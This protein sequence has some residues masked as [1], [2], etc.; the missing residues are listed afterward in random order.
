MTKSANKIISI[1]IKD[2]KHIQNVLNRLQISAK[3]K[4]SLLVKWLKF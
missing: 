1:A 4:T 3:I 2:M